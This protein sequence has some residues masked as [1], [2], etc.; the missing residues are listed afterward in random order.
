MEDSDRKIICEN[1]NSESIYTIFHPKLIKIRTTYFQYQ[2]MSSNKNYLLSVS[3]NL[4][5]WYYHR[6]EFTNFFIIGLT[7]LSNLGK[8]RNENTFFEIL[9]FFNTVCLQIIENQWFV[10]EI[11]KLSAKKNNFALISLNN[12]FTYWTLN[13]F[14]SNFH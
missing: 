12:I 13:R 4:S 14:L 8:S 9:F 1:M 11:I 7:F 5:W 3:I 2:N 6:V 10:T